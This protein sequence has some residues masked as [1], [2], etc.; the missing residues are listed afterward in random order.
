MA[1][2]DSGTVAPTLNVIIALNMAYQDI[3]KVMK[4]LADLSEIICCGLEST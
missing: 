1:I 2:A 4:E 3:V